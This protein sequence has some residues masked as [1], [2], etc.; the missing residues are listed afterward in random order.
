MGLRSNTKAII[1]D[2]MEHRKPFSR[3]NVTGRTVGQ[4]FGSFGRLPQEHRDAMR[5][6]L[7]H[8]QL[9]VVFSYQTPIAYGAE[10]KDYIVPDVSYS[11]STTQ[12]Q[13]AVRFIANTLNKY[14]TTESPK[15]R[16][17]TETPK[18]PKT[19]I[20]PKAPKTAPTEPILTYDDETDEDDKTYEIVR[21]YQDPDMHRETVETGL[22]LE[23]AEDHCNGK[24]ASS[25]TCTT[26]EGIA[27][28][29]EYGEWFE[30]YTEE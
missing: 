2:G 1:A 29:M 18:T 10:G 26:P 24:Q 6:L 21:F 3:G 7:Q 12:Q 14:N 19:R 15:S 4:Y 30:G 17:I 13:S 25:R 5:E 20:T 27:R 28:T 23:E 8:G 16:N 9:Y 22:T 11:P